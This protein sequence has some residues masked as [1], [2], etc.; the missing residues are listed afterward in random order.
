MPST[1]P[2]IEPETGEL[3]FDRIMYEAIPIAKLV[4]LVVGVAVLPFSLATL[5]GPTALGGLFALATQFVLA[6]GSGVVL[7]Y[8]VRR[9]LQLDG[10]DRAPAS[11]TTPRSDGPAGGTATDDEGTAAGETADAAGMADETDADRTDADE[12]DT[13]RADDATGTDQGDRGG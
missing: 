4:V 6:V 3:D 12:P 10:R 1:P 13:E 5:A 2:F 7:L 8:V 11:G 9:A